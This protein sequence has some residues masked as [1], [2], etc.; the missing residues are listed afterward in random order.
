MQGLPIVALSR[1]VATD[2]ANQHQMAILRDNKLLQK[3]PIC[4]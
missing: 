1:I 2:R 3:S 4:M